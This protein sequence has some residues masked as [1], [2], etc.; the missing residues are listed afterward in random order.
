MG[1]QRRIK[2][3]RDVGVLAAGVVNLGEPPLH[4]SSRPFSVVLG[5]H[6]LLSVFIWREYQRGHPP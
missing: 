2:S 5:D 3:A 6:S 4:G 1:G